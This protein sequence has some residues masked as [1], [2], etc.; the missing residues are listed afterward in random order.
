MD[1]FILR[2]E[3]I[4]RLAAVPGKTFDVVVAASDDARVVVA[5]GYHGLARVRRAPD[6]EAV[7]LAGP[8]VTAAAFSADDARFVTGHEDGVLRLLDA[9]TAASWPRAGPEHVAPLG[10]QPPCFNKGMARLR[11]YNQL[12]DDD[13]EGREHRELHAK[14]GPRAWP[15]KGA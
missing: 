10:D 1:Q 3:R 15:V 12:A 8:P 2:P 5:R 13:E 4:E 6:Y 14:S 9:G 11:V 7:P